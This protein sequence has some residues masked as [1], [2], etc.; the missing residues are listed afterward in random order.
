MKV[1]KKQI[2]FG[3]DII[4]EEDT[5]FIRFSYAGNLDLYCSIYSKDIRVNNNM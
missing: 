1:I 4:L 5:K 2:I 3:T